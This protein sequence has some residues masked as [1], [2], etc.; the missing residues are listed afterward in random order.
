M[1]IVGS[2]YLAVIFCFVT[3]LCWGSW[4]NTQK[5][6]TKGWPF[7]LYY[8]DYTIGVLVLSL[9][10]ALT[11]GNMGSEG[12]SFFT[13][14]AQADWSAAGSAFLGGVVFNLANIL[15]VVAIDLAGM[16]V[17]F[18][19]GIGL[20]LVVGVLINYLATPIGDPLFLFIGVAFVTV[21]IVLDALAYNKIEKTHSS[22]KGIGIS[23]LC[24][25][26]MGLF[27]RFVAAGVSLN[28]T[29]PEPGLM[30]PYTAVFIF[31]IG[32]VLSNFLW[33]SFFMYRPVSGN[34]VTYRQY[35]TEGSSKL[36]WVGLFGGIIWCIG[37]VFSMIASEKAG[38]A[39]SYGLGQG[40]TM[41]AAVWGVF[42]WKEFEDAPKGTNKLIGLMFLFFILGLGLIILSRLR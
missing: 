37:M 23:I 4:A 14:L 27:F 26:L 3:M 22:A 28:F 20:A 29:N 19:I 5:M 11:L 8:W 17:A 2:Y 15:L 6:A 12:R 35:F 33:N 34:P 38:F 30:T 41:V 24:G 10:F 39:I 13:D 36:H 40:A 25:F 18:P 9:V 42:V 1:F 32:V 21:A 31:S 7:Q 16:A